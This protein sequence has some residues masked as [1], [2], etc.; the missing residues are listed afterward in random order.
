MSDFT[1]MQNLVYS[2]TNRPDLISQTTRAIK[3]ATLKFHQADFWPRDL[4]EL[5]SQAV[6][7]VSSDYRYALDI[8]AAPFIRFRAL[9]YARVPS[10]D[11]T[12]KL[13]TFDRLNASDILDSYGIEKSDYWYLAGNTISIR[14][15][16]ALTNVAL[17]YYQFPDTNELTYTSW[18]ADTFPDAIAEEAASAIFK[19]TGKDDEYQRFTGYYEENKTFLQGS[20]IY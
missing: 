14:S 4:I 13:R 9:E 16:T 7:P 2:I 3:K 12:L 6:T 10:T 20:A 5:P 19:Q 18:I 11:P 17:G 8:T 15:Y 1:A